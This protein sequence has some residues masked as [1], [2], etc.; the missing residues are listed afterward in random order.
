[1]TSPLVPNRLETSRGGRHRPRRYE[2]KASQST[3]GNLVNL[4]CLL[5]AAPFLVLAGFAA[6]FHGRNT[7]PKEWSIMYSGI[8]A[9]GPLKSSPDTTIPLSRA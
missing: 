5:A 1:M 6:R 3:L 4:G 2:R 9:V 7:T 8:N